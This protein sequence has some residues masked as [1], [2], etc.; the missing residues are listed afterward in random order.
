MNKK[1][2]IRDQYIIIRVTLREKKELTL[3]SGKNISK[4]V[5]HK[6]GLK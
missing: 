2:D 5:R 6:L 4:Y 3:K 1:S